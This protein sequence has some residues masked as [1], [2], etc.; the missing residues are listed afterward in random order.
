MVL[1]IKLF[2]ILWLILLVGNCTSSKLPSLQTPLKFQVWDNI[3]YLDVEVNGKK[4][5]FIVDTGAALSLIDANQSKFYGFDVTQLDHT[6]FIQGF[7]SKNQLLATSHIKVRYRDL[8]LKGLKFRGSDL[9]HLNDFLQPRNIKILGIL[10][11]DY[12][13]RENAIID[14][15]RRALILN[16][17]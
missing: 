13:A 15:E 1:R 10:G 12:L 6:N 11:S 4:A 2:P 5:R 3:I 7:G 8:D 17:R 9:S 16:G 14:Y